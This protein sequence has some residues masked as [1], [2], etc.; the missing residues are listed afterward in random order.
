[1]VSHDNNNY[2]EIY[3]NKIIM[4]NILFKF[5]VDKFYFLCIILYRYQLLRMGNIKMENKELLLEKKCRLKY[6]YFIDIDQAIQDIRS[7]KAYKDFTSDSTYNITNLFQTI[8]SKIIEISKP[9]SEYILSEHH[10]SYNS[11]FGENPKNKNVQNLHTLSTIAL[12]HHC[13]TR[14]FFHL[15]KNNPT[16]VKNIPL[17]SSKK[18][19]V[20]KGF[21]RPSISKE[22]N[23]IINETKPSNDNARNKRL[24]NEKVDF[25]STAYLMTYLTEKVGKTRTSYYVP[26]YASL[27]CYFLWLEK[28]V[29]CFSKSLLNTSES[30]RSQVNKY[31]N[32]ASA[33]LKW[34]NPLSNEDKFVFKIFAESAFGFSVFPYIGELLDNITFTEPSTVKNSNNL[35]DLESQGFISLLIDAASLPITFNRTILL[36]YACEAILDSPELES[37]FP[38]KRNNSAAI[39][40]SVTPKSKTLFASKALDLLNSYYRMLSQITLPLLEDLWDVFTAELFPKKDLEFDCYLKFIIEHYH[41]ITFDYTSIEPSTLP[42][43]PFLPMSNFS[44]YYSLLENSSRQKKAIKRNITFTSK[45]TQ[46]K[47]QYIL[48]EY[49]NTPK[50]NNTNHLMIDTILEKNA[51]SSPISGRYFYDNDRNIFLENHVN[52]IFNFSKILWKNHPDKKIDDFHSIFNC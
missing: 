31:A 47:L 44:H 10:A 2:T 36:K 49:C 11:L 22:E 19:D 17:S 7:Q 45:T 4:H 30:A 20:A 38:A 5:L 12:F 23:P 16:Y 24:K 28:D 14:S 50:A 42:N 52:S 41:F 32:M 33:F 6:F 25:Y 35:K 26:K 29:A 18:G 34:Y 51:I 48:K 39:Y 21:L 27:F 13:I 3:Q 15:L 8:F 37:Q 9:Y 40:L 43:N 46:K 1:M